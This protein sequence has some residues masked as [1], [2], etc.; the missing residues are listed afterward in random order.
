M[1]KIRIISFIITIVLI[2]IIVGGIMI[3]IFS[4]NSLLDST[5][6]IIAFLVSGVSVA[7]ALLSQISAYRERKT[8]ARIIRELQ[9]I[10]KQTEADT[11]LDQEASKKLDELL[12]LDRRIYRQVSANTKRKAKK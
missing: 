6:E 12:A 4:A 10:I 1:R 3:Q 7:I 8:Y 11:A 2:L 9:A 5:Y